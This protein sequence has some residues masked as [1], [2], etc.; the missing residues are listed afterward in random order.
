MISSYTRLFQLLEKHPKQINR[1]ECIS[2]TSALRQAVES[3][4]GKATHVLD[5]DGNNGTS[6][7]EGEETEK[8]QAKNSEFREGTFSGLSVFALARFPSFWQCYHH[9]NEY[10]CSKRIFPTLVSIQPGTILKIF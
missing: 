6:G 5:N 3:I 7:R 10:V 9:T 2:F 8:E 4:A 1:K